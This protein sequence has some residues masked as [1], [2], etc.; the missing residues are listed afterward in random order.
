MGMSTPGTSPSLGP[1]S[2]RDTI[3]SLTETLV[4]EP[5]RASSPATIPKAG[6]LKPDG[7]LSVS[8]PS[9][10]PKYS[11]D[12]NFR[13]QGR[14]SSFNSI[15]SNSQISGASS[16]NSTP[17]ETPP[18]IFADSQMAHNSSPS[19]HKNNTIPTLDLPQPAIADSELSLGLRLPSST[20]VETEPSQYTEQ[21]LLDEAID[22]GD[23]EV[24]LPKAATTSQH[25]AFEHAVFDNAVTLC[26][27]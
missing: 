16:P 25:E 5:T 12:L 7:N 11:D 6:L 3:S 14:T 10:S 22:S 21:V 19:L 20:I 4:A 23:E 1:L 2:R 26:K 18:T 8:G 27:G 9:S 13:K 17:Y 15:V 24:R